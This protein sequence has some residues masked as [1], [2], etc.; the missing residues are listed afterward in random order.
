VRKAI[1]KHKKLLTKGANYHKCTR[2]P[3]DAGGCGLDQL[4]LS[5][6]PQIHLAPPLTKLDGSQHNQGM[7]AKA[8][9]LRDATPNTE[10]EF[11]L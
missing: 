4:S 6:S 11:G 2:S 3:L 10:K 9:L 7:R 5:L 1:M 8:C